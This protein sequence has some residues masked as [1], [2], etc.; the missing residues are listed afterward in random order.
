MDPPVKLVVI[1]YTIANAFKHS[2]TLS[3]YAYLH[4]FDLYQYHRVRYRG[5]LEAVFNF[6]RFLAEKEWELVLMTPVENKF[7]SFWFVNSEY[8]P[9][10]NRDYLLV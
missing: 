6:T 5:I 2:S 4:N 8:I 10:T 1:F 9:F 3:F 7:D